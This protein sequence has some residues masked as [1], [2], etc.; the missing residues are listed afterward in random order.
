[1]TVRDFLYGNLPQEILHSDVFIQTVK[2][3]EHS[4]YP[5]LLVQDSELMS[6]IAENTV[7][8]D[9]VSALIRNK[10]YLCSVV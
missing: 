7:V 5:G 2:L 4:N 6:L 1:M 9:M 3:L 8:N 10:I